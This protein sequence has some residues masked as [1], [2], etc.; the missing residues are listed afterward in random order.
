MK[1]QK[2]GPCS[3]GFVPTRG[4][5]V[6]PERRRKRSRVVISTSMLNHSIR[7]S[8]WSVF[9]GAPTMRRMQEI[10]AVLVDRAEERKMA[11]SI[12]LRDQTGMLVA[13]RSTP[14]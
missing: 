9:V 3:G 5:A 1:R 8:L 11:P 12:L 7:S 4:R 2:V 6:L 10:R 14:V 13:A